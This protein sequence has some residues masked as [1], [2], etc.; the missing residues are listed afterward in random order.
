MSQSRRKAA[1][2]FVLKGWRKDRGSIDTRRL[3]CVQHVRK[4]SP[5]PGAKPSFAE[6]PDV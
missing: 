3:F 5:Y 1:L 4:R 2:L 6:R